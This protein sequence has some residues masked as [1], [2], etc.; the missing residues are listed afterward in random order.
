MICHNYKDVKAIEVGKG[1][2]VRWLT[3]KDMGGEEYVHNHALRQFIIGP[4]SG[5]ELHDH[6]FVQIIFIQKGNLLFRVQDKDGKLT[7][8]EVGPGDVIYT[9]AW[10]PHG[11]R[12]QSETEPVELLCCIDC[13]DGK[14]NCIQN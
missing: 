12:N 6:K 9:H 13:V 3:H 7:E 8:R 14:D 4:K 11:I 2:L 5:V 10:E 1:I